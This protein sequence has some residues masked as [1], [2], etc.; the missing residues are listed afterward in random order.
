MSKLTERV[1]QAAVPIAAQQG[2]SVWD[3]EY[4][5][6]AGAFFLRIYIDHPDGVTIDQC[7]AVSH[8]ISDWLDETDPIA[9]SYTLE[10][11]SAGADRVLKRPSDFAA[12]MGKEISVR[13]YQPRDKKKEWIGTLAE[14]DAGAVVLSVPQK[15]GNIPVRFEKNEIAQVRLYVAW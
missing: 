4:V 3:V 2:C 7:E 1:T 11:S 9:E 15:T 14:Y 10:V 13:L 8:A 5:K 6:E 12:F